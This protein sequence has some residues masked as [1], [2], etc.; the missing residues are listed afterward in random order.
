MS[1][2]GD[3]RYASRLTS[4]EA[5]SETDLVPVYHPSGGV[6]VERA[7][8]LSDIKAAGGAGSGANMFLYKTD[9]ST[10]TPSDPGK[11]KIRWNNVDQASATML[12][13]DWLTMD[14]FDPV[15]MFQTFPV[16][17]TFIIQEVDFSLNHQVW[18]KTAPAVNGPDYF[19]VE[20]E[21]VSV[22]GLSQFKNQ[23]PVAILLQMSGMARRM[24]DLPTSAKGLPEGSLWNNKGVINIVC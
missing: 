21:L 17:D 7:I 19:T 12:I 14:G 15:L 20:V 16:G 11:G 8:S 18:R 10:T 6:N 24:P 23:L 3:L 4:E 5:D 1:D 9:I 2:I 13:L 22:N